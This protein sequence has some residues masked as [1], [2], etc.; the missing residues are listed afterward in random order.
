MDRR[1]EQAQVDDLLDEIRDEVEI[2]SHGIDPAADVQARL[3]AYRSDGKT[4]GRKII[5]M[6]TLFM[7]RIM[8]TES[9][10]LQVMVR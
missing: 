3:D 6:V 5:V 7:M 1:S 2:D 10:R 4:T 8:I 9:K